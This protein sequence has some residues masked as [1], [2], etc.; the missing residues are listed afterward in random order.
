MQR[1]EGMAEVK[2]ASW[3]HFLDQAPSQNTVIVALTA[4]VFLLWLLK[5][6]AAGPAPS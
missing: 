5:L 1:F 3:L 4:M 2:K 6:V